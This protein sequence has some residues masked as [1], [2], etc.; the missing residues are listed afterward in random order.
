MFSQG[1]G[2]TVEVDTDGLT[3]EWFSLDSATITPADIDGTAF[4]PP[5]DGPAVLYLKR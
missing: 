5:F 3:G 1:G 2:F 4:T